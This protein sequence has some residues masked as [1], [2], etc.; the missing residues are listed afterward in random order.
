MSD[1]SQYVEILAEIDRRRARNKLLEYKPYPKQAEF[2]KQKT[3]E[4]L[5]AAA[6]RV[7]K[8]YSAAAQTA[9][10]LTGKYPDW[11]EGIRLHKPCTGVVAGKTAQLVRDSCQILLCGAPQ[12]EL[13]TGYIPGADIVEAMMA[14]G[15]PG[16]FDLVRVKH[17]N[18]LG[19]Y[20]GDSLLYFRAFEQGREKIQA[21][22]LDFMWLDEECD[23]DYY[24]EAITRT[25][26]TMGP[27]YMTFT[28]LLGMSDVVKRFLQEKS[29][30]RS[31][32]NMTIDDAL[33]FSPEDRAKI[34]ASYPAHERDARTK[35]V[36][37]LGGG[38]VFP[39]SEEEIKTEA[40]TIPAHW[41]RICGMDFGWDHPTAAS[42]LAWDR[43]NDTVYVYDCYRS[44]REIISTHASAIKAKGQWIPVAWPHDGMQ[45]DKDAGIQLSDQYRNQGLNMLHTYAQFEKNAKDESKSSTISIE[46]GIADMLERMQTGRFKVFSHLNDWFEE[47]RM[48]HRKDGKI[49]KL[50]DD[51]LSSTR[52][53]TM[54][55]RYS[56]T[57]TKTARGK[58]RKPINW[59][60]V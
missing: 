31:V 46:A 45:N 41:P 43:D 8:T 49:V 28:P 21:M 56:T 19:T 26:T 58:K 32:V 20:D 9:M 16:A 51:I 27:I 1:L 40:F 25:N 3:R 29:E 54:M 39:V 11:W 18:K 13:G 14:R 55:L 52:Y 33:H 5:F 30:D 59:K 48:Y 10:H 23:I 2:H 57:N 60:A 34:I 47:F 7:G 6:N 53:A 12:T 4:V 15:V 22:T 37:M 42:W 50:G 36:P 17:Y 35:G 44:K 24:T 38:A